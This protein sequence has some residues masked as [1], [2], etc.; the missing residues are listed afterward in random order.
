MSQLINRFREDLQ[1]A[2]YAKRS[3]ESYVSSVIRTVVSGVL[4][5]PNAANPQENHAKYHQLPHRRFR[6]HCL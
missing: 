2:G 1:L 6:N 3:S 4:C 5:R